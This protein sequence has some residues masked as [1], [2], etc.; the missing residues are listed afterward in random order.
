MSRTQRFG[1]T[2]RIR[3]VIADRNIVIIQLG[4]KVGTL[5]GLDCSEGVLEY[6]LQWCLGRLPLTKFQPRQIFEME[7]FCNMPSRRKSERSRSFARLFISCSPR[8]IPTLTAGDGINYLSHCPNAHGTVDLIWLWKP[9]ALEWNFPLSIL[10]IPGTSAFLFR[11]L[12]I[13]SLKL[14]EK[15][16]R[17]EKSNAWN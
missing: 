7:S 17:M 8:Q 10:P 9:E 6:V 16:C 11:W 4:F 14:M 2:A 1:T 12:D 15:G 5:G 3:M 13:I